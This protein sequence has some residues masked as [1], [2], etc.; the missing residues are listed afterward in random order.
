MSKKGKITFWNNRKGYGFISPTNGGERV[1]V[2]IKAFC[3]RRHKPV[4]GQS[5]TYALSTDKHGRTC[6]INAMQ[7][8]AQ[9]HRKLKT[10]K[11]TPTIIVA[12]VFLVIVGVAAFVSIVASVIFLTYLV[13]SLVTFI[14]YAVDKSAAEE[15]KWRTPEST[16]HVL[17]LAGGW[18]GALIAQDKLSHKTQKKSFQVVFWLT[19]IINFAVFIWALTPGGETTLENLLS[20]AAL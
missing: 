5:I 20:M 16:L 11:L 14:L 15:G 9:S 17:S 7:I 2:H 10:Q 8:G 19:V 12:V 6:A 18:P 3:D 4:V 13:T 1:F